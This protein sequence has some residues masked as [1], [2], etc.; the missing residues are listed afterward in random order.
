[1]L[2]ANSTSSATSA[3]LV[4][5]LAAL[6]RLQAQT[7]RHPAKPA[8]TAPPVHRLYS[9]LVKGDAMPLPVQGSIGGLFSGSV[10]DAKGD[11]FAMFGTGL[12]AGAGQPVNTPDVYQTTPIRKV[13]PS[14][15]G[16]PSA[17][18]YSTQPPPGYAARQRVWFNA[19]PD[20]RLY[21]LI[22]ASKDPP[23]QGAHI[24]PDPMIVR[25]NDDGSIDTAVKLDG[26]PG[27][28]FEPLNFAPFANGM[29][30]VA[31]LGKG[32]KSEPF[33]P[34][35][36]VFDSFGKFIA[37][38]RQEDQELGLG[39]VPGTA[40]YRGKA[41]QPN[42]FGPMASAPDGNV[43][44]VMQ[45]SEPHVFAISPAGMIVKDFAIPSRGAGLDRDD[46]SYTNGM[47]VVSRTW[48]AIAF[49][50]APSQSAPMPHTTLVLVDLVSGDIAAAIDL[51]SAVPPTAFPVCAVAQ[52]TWYFLAQAA[53]GR[54]ELVK[55]LLK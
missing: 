51:N 5:S 37:E 44:V 25:Y 39:D 35:A 30:L 19:D 42:P 40:R 20:G 16:V 46:L 15:S 9:T 55:Y 21:E 14:T 49:D 11:L 48:L 31:G 22:R 54:P 12:S 38:V 47:G 36:A 41:A 3:I 29:F 23:A 26:I 28:S 34:I 53:D 6:G 2:R 4:L 8:E 10:C 27:K 33:P 7:S 52:D 45:L 17:T 43:Y 50:R 13:S 24:L 1:M 32:S 18:S